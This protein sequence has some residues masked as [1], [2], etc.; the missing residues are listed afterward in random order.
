MRH[1]R[2]PRGAAG[3]EGRRPGVPRRGH[4]LDAPAGR[5]ARLRGQRRRHP[6]RPRG[7][8]AGRRSSAWCSRRAPRRVGPAAA[9]RHRRRDASCSPPA[10][11]G[12]PY[13]N[14]VHEREA[15][16]MRLAARGLPLVCVNP[17]ARLRPGRHPRDLH[18]A[19]PQ[20]PAGPG[21][22]VRRR[23][24]ST[25][26]TCATWRSA[27]CWPT[28]AAGSASATSSAGATSPSTASSPTSA[29]C[30]GVDPPRQGAARPGRGAR[31]RFSRSVPDAPR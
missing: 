8:P 11:C 3:A 21:A 19:G 15:E 17:A 30:R 4:D 22:G 29:A 27:T 5:R 28:S 16:A 14:S 12:I 20:L 9:R 6:D 13:V 18:A 1:P 2:P 24:R 31:A 26:S 25:S 10:R 7:V 23:R